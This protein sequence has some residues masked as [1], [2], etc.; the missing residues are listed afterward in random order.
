M[1]VHVTD[2]GRLVDERLGKPFQRGARGPGAFYCLG[3]WL[4]LLE[5]STGIV[6]QDPFI[7]PEEEAL[8][9]FWNR[10]IR[11]EQLGEL[12]PLDIL[13][14]RSGPDAHV[15]TVEDSRWGVSTS[16]TAGVFR[17]PLG[18]LIR[19]ASAIYRLREFFR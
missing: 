12:R 11:F 17:A 8:R 16:P 15:A 6:I 19:R 14:W 2:L 4:D 13:F 3:L 10:F 18:D 7:R 9:T 5:A 1:T